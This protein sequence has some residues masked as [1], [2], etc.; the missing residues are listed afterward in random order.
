MMTAR[1]RCSVC[2]FTILQLSA[3]AAFAETVEI[4]CNR[5]NTLYESA[6]GA[7]SNGE[8]QS[9]F[10]GNTGTGLIRRALVHF[11]VPDLIP[12]GSTVNSVVLRMHL[13]QRQAGTVTLRVHALL[14]DWGEGASVAPGNG[15]AGTTPAPGDATWL[16]RFHPNDFWATAGGDYDPAVTASLAVS[17][18]GYVLWGSNAALVS[19]VQGWISTPSSNFGWLIRT[20]EGG[21]FEGQRFDSR[22]SES[23]WYRPVLIVDFTPSIVAVGDR[24]IGAPALLL[25]GALPAHGAVTFAIHVPED[26]TAAIEILDARGAL[27][28]R[29]EGGALNAGDHRLTWDGSSAHGGDAAAGLYFARLRFRGEI[30][31]VRFVRLR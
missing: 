22:E 16:H 28:R 4:P 29:L 31:V 26:G 3:A 10:A 25:V 20:N 24:V 30:S 27:V 9:V 19:Q 8:G 7:L 2:L 11:P 15:G 18:T 1:R 12:T 6:T 21:T 5:D 23:T 17:D 14:A 13:A